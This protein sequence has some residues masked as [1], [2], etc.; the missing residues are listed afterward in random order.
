MF[1]RLS[2]CKK[3]IFHF[4][5]SDLTVT[6][7]EFQPLS[8]VLNPLYLPVCLL[9]GISTVMADRFPPGLLDLPL[10][11][12]GWVTHSVVT[13]DLSSFLPLLFTFSSSESASKATLYHHKCQATASNPGKLF[14]TFS[15][16]NPPSPISYLLGWLCQVLYKRVGILSSLTEPTG[17]THRTTAWPLTPI[18]L[19]IISCDLCPAGNNLPTYSIPSSI[20]QTIS[21][22]LLPFLTS[23]INTSQTT[24]CIPSDFKMAR[25][26]LPSSRNQHSK[27]TDRH[28]FLLFPKQFSVLSLTNCLVIPVR[29]IFL[30]LT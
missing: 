29:R 14:S 6:W 11:L 15:S 19:Q 28:T 24:G 1:S 7:R 27:T 12:R 18:S 4:S 3:C 26:S 2:F 20:I 25:E 8:V 10:L 17:H 30:T 9:L 23:F 13:E 22:D 21:G 16:L 5:L